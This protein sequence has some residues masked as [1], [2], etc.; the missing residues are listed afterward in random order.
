MTTACDRCGWPTGRFGDDSFACPRCER[1]AVPHRFSRITPLYRYQDAVTAVVVA[2][3][4]PSNSAIT[5]ELAHR[6]ATRCRGRW[7]DL[8]SNE[9]PLDENLPHPP[10]VTS[11]PSPW[12]RQARRGGSGTRLLA[13]YFARSMGWRYHGL[14]RTTRSI[15][16]QAWLDD[17]ARRENVRGAF[18]LKSRFSSMRSAVAGRE[19]ILVDDVM[20]T[21]ATAD[22]VA[23]VLCDAG[24]RR[25]SLAV[26]AIAIRES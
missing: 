4:Y 10:I 13:K 7:G 5:W 24:A 18:A 22:E 1:L 11:V 3:K 9:N 2:A 15:A 14:L 17:E 8:S 26:V 21:G 16:K 23:G 12:W 19:I 20:T 6:L 25:V